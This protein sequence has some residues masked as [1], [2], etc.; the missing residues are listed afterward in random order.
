MA[1]LSPVAHIYLTTSGCLY[2]HVQRPVPYLDFQLSGLLSLN[3]ISKYWLKIFPYVCHSPLKLDISNLSQGGVDSLMTPWASRTA[4]PSPSQADENCHLGR[5]CF[6]LPEIQGRISA[7]RIRISLS[8]SLRICLLAHSLVT[9]PANQAPIASR[10]SNWGWS[11][12]LTGGPL[13]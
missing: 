5:R 3:K 10:H 6:L 13:G 2:Q 11:G 4:V 7:V 8:R 1:L 9:A 12:C